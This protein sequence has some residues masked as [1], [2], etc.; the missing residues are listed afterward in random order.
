MVSYHNNG[1]TITFKN[2]T[3]VM[4]NTHVTCIVENSWSSSNGTAMFT[5]LSKLNYESFT[6]E[7][8]ISIT[9]FLVR[10]EVTVNI[11]MA[12]HPVIHKIN[13]SELSPITPGSKLTLLCIAVGRK[14]PR[15]RWYHTFTELEEDLLSKRQKKMLVS[16]D[17]TEL[18]LDDVSNSD[19]GIHP[20]FLYH[21]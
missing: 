14:Q 9:K 16:T 4:H 17:S 18:S 11:F 8:I 5:V 20:K 3:D 10:L 19:E 21:V 15:I 6:N 2:V 13:V 12:A 1:T 7:K